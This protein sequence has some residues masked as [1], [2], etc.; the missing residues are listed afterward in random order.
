[1]P[2]LGRAFI[3]QHNRHYIIAVRAT[4]YFMAGQEIPGRT[5]YSG[6]LGAGDGRFG[7]AEVLACTGLDLDEDQRAVSIDHDEINLTGFAEKIASEGLETLAC[8]ELLGVF[9][10]PAAELRF[11]P[12]PAGKP[13]SAARRTFA[14]K[15]KNGKS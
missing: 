4:L 1:M 7:R 11:V 12:A 2:D 14:Q 9:F 8:E 13:Q 15:R 3:R 6:P 10:A 5:D